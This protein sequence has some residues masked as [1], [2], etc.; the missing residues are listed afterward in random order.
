MTQN[1]SNQS[2][3]LTKFFEFQRLEHQASQLD[4]GV[5]ALLN[6]NK[7]IALV[8]DNKR[9]LENSYRSLLKE[10]N[11]KDDVTVSQLS[12]TSTEALIKMFNQIMSSVSLDTALRPAVDSMAINV[13]LVNDAHLV[14]AEQW[15]LLSQLTSDFPGAQ[16]RFVLVINS[17]EWSNFESVIDEF[18]VDMHICHLSENT[19]SLSLIHI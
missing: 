1:T 19:I 3:S 13:L 6:E 15:F 4:E 12:S 2:E 18:K 17:E 8:S 11:S 5:N 7:G 14:S 16:I 10:L 9:C